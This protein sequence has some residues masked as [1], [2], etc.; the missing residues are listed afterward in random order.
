[1][2]WIDNLPIHCL[3]WDCP[4]GSSSLQADIQWTN[5]VLESA[6]WKILYLSVKCASIYIIIMIP[7]QCVINQATNNTKYKLAGNISQS[8]L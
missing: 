5:F 8:L 1:M 4:V 6:L 3:E 2:F 7:V